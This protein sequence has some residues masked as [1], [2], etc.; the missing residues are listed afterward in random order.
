[1]TDPANGKTI[2]SVTPAVAG[3]QTYYVIKYKG[4]NTMVSWSK[5]GTIAKFLEQQ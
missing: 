4:G 3:S 2:I 5:T 1:M